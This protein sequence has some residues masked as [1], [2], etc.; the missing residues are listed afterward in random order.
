MLS[1]VSHYCAHNIHYYIIILWCTNITRAEFVRFVLLSWCFRIMHMKYN[2]RDN[3]IHIIV[4]VDCDER[5]FVNALMVRGGKVQRITGLDG[6]NND[7]GFTSNISKPS[8]H[9]WRFASS[10]CSGRPFRFSIYS[11]ICTHIVVSTDCMHMRN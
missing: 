11:F 3:N 5:P 2:S 7:N 1:F 9:L 10:Y 4:V 8:F 6:N